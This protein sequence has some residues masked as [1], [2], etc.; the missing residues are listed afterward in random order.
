MRPFL[1]CIIVTCTAAGLWCPSAIASG[2]N[3][4]GSS[5]EELQESETEAI[6]HTSSPTSPPA[7]VPA[8]DYWTSPLP[9]V[10]ARV[11]ALTEFNGNLI[12]GGEFNKAGIY[13]ASKKLSRIKRVRTRL[14]QTIR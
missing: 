10:N 14:V 11:Y 2:R 3:S 1:A 4:A 6:A 5:Q 13:N 12:A 9:G 8:V 7:S